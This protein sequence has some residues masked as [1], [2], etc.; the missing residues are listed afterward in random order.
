MQISPQQVGVIQVGVIQVGAVQVG[1]AP[2]DLCAATEDAGSLRFNAEKQRLQVCDGSEWKTAGGAKLEANDEACTS[3]NA[4]VTRF[5]DGAFSFCDGAEWFVV[6][7]QP[8]NM[9]TKSPTLVPGKSIHNPVAS[10]KAL[11]SG[12]SSGL[13]YI[14][15]SGGTFLGYCNMD[16]DGGGWL[17]V[18]V[19][20]P[21]SS[22][23]SYARQDSAEH[24]SRLD[25]LLFTAVA[26]MFIPAHCSAAP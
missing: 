13:Y 5:Q 12:A 16:T 24:F 4:G 2:D 10:C 6:L 3:D 9:P 23:W 15:P 7:G 11:P 26:W 22:G 17:R 1:A 25:A 19:G 21:P 14:G 18:A 8:T 20:T